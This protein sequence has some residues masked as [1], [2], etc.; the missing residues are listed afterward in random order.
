LQYRAK[1][2]N[3]ILG[4]PMKYLGVPSLSYEVGAYTIDKHG[5]LH[6]EYNI[7]IADGIVSGWI[8]H[9]RTSHRKNCRSQKP[10]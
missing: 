4:Q 8:L 9:E 6:G 7:G 2:A 5:T 10:H 1:N 3:E